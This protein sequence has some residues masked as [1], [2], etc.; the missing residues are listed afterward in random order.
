MDAAAVRR[1]DG[2][3]RYDLRPLTGWAAE[4]RREQ[5]Q[6]RLSRVLKDRLGMNVRQGVRVIV[7]FIDVDSITA[8]AGAP[9]HQGR[10]S[11]ARASRTTGAVAPQQVHSAGAALPQEDVHAAVA[12]AAAVRVGGAFGDSVD[13]GAAGAGTLGEAVSE[14]GPEVQALREGELHQ[15]PQQ[16]PATAGP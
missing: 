11:S 7:S 14:P 16:R 9:Q 13:G 10:T 15:Q 1:N 12:A 5:N 8:A 2:N 6:K 4:K 3:G